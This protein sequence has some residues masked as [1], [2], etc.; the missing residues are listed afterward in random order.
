MSLL[1]YRTFKSYR[2]L[3]V[4]LLLIVWGVLACVP[5]QNHPQL[6]A[7]ASAHPLATKAGHAILGQGGNA[8]DAAVAVS[9]VLA[10][11]EPMS[12]GLGGGGFWLL[13]RS[14]DN[15]QVMIDGREMAPGASTADM[16]LGKS[17]ELIPG[18][19]LNGALAA[20]IPGLPAALVHIAEGYG[21][22]PLSQSLAPA[23]AYARKGFSVTPRFRRLLA[24]RQF[25]LSPAA[26]DIFLD[27]N[28]LPALGTMIRQPDLAKTLEAIA[29]RGR[30]GFYGGEVGRL[31]VAGARADGGIWTQSDLDGYFVVERQPVTGHYGDMQVTSVALPS[32][33]GIVLMQMLNMLSNFKLVEMM[34]DQRNHTLVEVMRRAYR[35]RAR[36]LGDADF[37]AV[38][39]QALLADAYARKL[40][41]DLNPK[42]TPSE[43]LNGGDG[44]TALKPKGTDT[45]H[46][47]IIDHEGNRVAATL[48]INYPF[49]SG[50]VA[51]GTG[52][53]LNNEMDDFSVKPGW[54]NVYGLVGS[55]ANA[56][57]PGKRP[58]SSMTPSF[59]ETPEAVLVIGT[60][61]GSRII[62]MVLLAAL[63]FAEGRGGPQQWVALPRFHHQFIPDE[64]TLE[65]GAWGEKLKQKMR[66]RGHVL[67]ERKR[68]YGNMHVVVWN[69]KTKK[70]SAASDPRGEGL[71]LVK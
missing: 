13:H 49:G 55:K 61:G 43:R 31:L 38:D 70:L 19:S 33:G 25:S 5:E 16:Y 17:G 12:S 8:F 65:P 68:V 50:F 22:L 37:I 36:F 21:L 44:K 46:F 56:I 69:K 40:I 54:P 28:E 23:I 51:P 4:L 15:F 57:E 6:A 60:P 35:D 53:L 7:I 26:Q 10:V 52:V 42:A 41:A 63:E 24:F 34:P 47:S 1:N 30:E 48:S 39:S 20:G 11:V 29:Q 59:F 3:W 14:A 67:K 64:I 71:A 62:T 18:A 27:F 9:A 2:G 58:L 66:D 32:S 45:T